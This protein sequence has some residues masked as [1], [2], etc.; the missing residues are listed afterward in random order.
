MSK[1]EGPLKLFLSILNLQ[2]LEILTLAMVR[3][4]P[5]LRRLSQIF[6]FCNSAT[7]WVATRINPRFVFNA[8]TGVFVLGRHA[9]I[10]FS[11]AVQLWKWSKY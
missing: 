8:G 4:R 3:A 5:S 10:H 11:K 6:V 1:F 2:D 7:V 9:S